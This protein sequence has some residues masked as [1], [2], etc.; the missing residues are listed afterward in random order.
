MNNPPGEWTVLSML[1]WAT[2]YFKSKGIKSPRLS[3]EWLLAHA[4]K[5]KRLDLY[6]NHERP[7]STK[8]LTELRTLVKRRTTHEPL[9][10]VVGETH[11][12][13]SRILVNPSVLIPRQETELLVDMILEE[14]RD[15]PKKLIDLGTGSGCIP[16]AIKKAR[17][18]WEVQAS[19]ISLDALNT[20]SKN[21]LINEVEVEFFEHSFFEKLPDSEISPFDIVVSNPPYI[22]LDEKDSLD[23][24]VKMF[25]PDL[26]LFCES[27]EKVYK[28]LEIFCGRY[29]SERGKAYFEIHEHHVNEVHEIF[30]ENDWVV[31]THK[32]LESK[33]RFIIIE[34]QKA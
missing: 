29:L 22:L 6:L 12:Y 16:I 33:D 10:Y 1:N 2:D 34:H 4:L 32:D 25:E 19:D 18:E 27:T 7:L 11:F 26:A 20:A 9:Q 28:A 3:I 5:V 17:K 8:E 23:D 15:D 21:A 31:K 14:Y 30:S 13:N 24:E